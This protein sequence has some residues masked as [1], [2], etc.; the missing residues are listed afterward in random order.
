MARRFNA[1]EWLESSWTCSVP[2]PM[3]LAAWRVRDNTSAY[4]TVICVG[5]NTQ[6]IDFNALQSMAS[7]AGND[8]GISF[9]DYAETTGAAVNTSLHFQLVEFDTNIIRHQ[10]DNGTATTHAWT[11]AGSVSYNRIQI[12]K[13]VSTSINEFF[14][15]LIGH[16][17]VWNRILTA[18]EKTSLYNQSANPQTVQPSYLVAYL[19]FVADSVDATGRTWTDHYT[20]TPAYESISVSYPALGSTGTVAQSQRRQTQ[21]IAGTVLLPASTGTVAASQKRQKQ[22]VAGT[23]T[24]PAGTGTVAQSQKRQTQ[25]IAGT[26]TIHVITGTVAQSQRRQTQ[27][28]VGIIPGTG[29]T[30]DHTNFDPAGLSASAITAASALK[31]YFEHASTGQDI[32]GNSNTDSSTGQN[33]DETADC[34]MHQL[35]DY[36][37]RYLC[38]RSSADGSNDYTWFA[39]HNGLQSN[40]RGNP[41]PA[42]KLSGFVGMSAN[43]RAAVKVAMMKYCWID[44]WDGT[45][46]NDPTPGY[47]A[48]GATWAADMIDD[49]EAFEA[50]NPS[51]VNVWWTMPLEVGASYPARQNFN[52][53][54]RTYCTDHNKYLIDIADIECHD[55]NGNIQLDGNGREVA[56]DPYMMPDGGHLDVSG[57]IRMGRAYWT[58]MSL[59]AS[60]LVTGTVAQSQ[61][62]QTEAIAGTVALQALTGTVAQSQKRQTEAIAGTVALQALTG[63]VAASQKRQTQAVAGTVEV[64]S[65]TGTISESQKRQTQA[66]SGT[67]TIPSVTGTISSSQKLQTQSVAGTITAPSVTGTIAA[68]QKK[69]TQAITGSI[70]VPAVTGTISENQKRQTQAVAGIVASPGEIVGMVLQSQVRQT[71]AVAGTVV[72][73]PLT[74]TITQEQK[75]QI[76]SIAGTVTIPGVTGTINQAQKRQEERLIDIPISGFVEWSFDYT[77]STGISGILI[78]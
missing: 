30:I 35:Y 32:V 56:Y 19:P 58:A 15:G 31:V 29:R 48:D 55:T 13:T 54:I 11:A 28:I 69:Q 43:M 51:I 9:N 53:A 23:V 71:Q 37:N 17:M 50:A 60:E 77:V 57:R 52:E 4:S 49:I 73:P 21:A 63:T 41:T 44:V 45:N 2:Q 39:T 12:S 24:L 42:I 27:A 68:S 6:E 36:N 18:N 1:A 47:I 26:T 20:T 7:D 65:A 76:Q 40:M 5:D 33:Q 14:D 61:K 8:K 38:S 34:G 64:P 59:V 46:Y 78:V 70:T 22:A 75:R 25:A 74:G 72:D 10:L 67:V 16:V 3:T 62:R 66:I